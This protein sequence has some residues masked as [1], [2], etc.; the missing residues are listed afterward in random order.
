MER[1]RDLIGFGMLSLRVKR[2]LYS[3]R[4]QNVAFP[5]KLKVH[6]I[7]KHSGNR[8]RIEAYHITF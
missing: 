4:Q 7:F 3:K 2:I 1:Q 5:Q 6:D 8:P